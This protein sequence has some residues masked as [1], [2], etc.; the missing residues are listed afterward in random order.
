MICVLN[1]ELKIKKH[2]QI[3]RPQT[4]GFWYSYN[5][6][7]VI[8]IELFCMFFV[9][10]LRLGNF[11]YSNRPQ[12]SIHW[13]FETSKKKPHKTWFKLQIWL[14][15]TYSILYLKKITNR[16]N[17]NVKEYLYFPIIIINH[18]LIGI[19]RHNKKWVNLA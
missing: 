5:V 13:T 10:G 3:L 17:V 2:R 8:P 14:L 1:P 12:M 16:V 18:R 4:G 15:R 19:E 6:L 9:A 11:F 7:Y